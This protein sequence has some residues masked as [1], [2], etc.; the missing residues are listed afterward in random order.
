MTDILGATV[1]FGAMMGVMRKFGSIGGNIFGGYLTDKFGTGKIMMLAFIVMLGG[2]ITMLFTPA[3][4]SGI[5]VVAILFVTI[6]V[7]FN[8][9]YAMAWTM[10]SEGA[11]PV[12]NSGTAAGLIC[13]AG[14]IP[15]IFVTL[16]AGKMIDSN[17][18]VKG[19]HHFFYFLTGVII[20]GL[21]LI[22]V[23]RKYLNHIGSRCKK[24]D[25]KT[26]DELKQYV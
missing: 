1:A 2:Q 11:I 12:E 26:M 21:L 10:M 13:T 19:Y 25:E 17:P 16:L 22:I 5:F 23:W 15:E 24:M 3:K 4:E 8:M 18:G 7:F 9:N 20:F 14:A 6:L